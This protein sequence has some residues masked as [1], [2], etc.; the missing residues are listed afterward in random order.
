[1]KNIRRLLAGAALL[2][3]VTATAP[4]ASAQW[5][6]VGKWAVADGMLWTTPGLQ[7]YSGREAAALLFGGLYTNYAISTNGTDPN[8]I[9]FSAFLDGYGDTQFLTAPKGQDFKD[10]TGADYQSGTPA[11]SAYVF[12]HACDVLGRGYYCDNGGGELAINYAFVNTTV[13]EPGTYALMAFG[14]V[15]MV[16]V[17]RKRRNA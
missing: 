12:D 15:G 9:N 8:Q 14:L 13:P 16:G 7:S 5:A 6:Y 4:T 3:G 10:Q 2:I 1:M 11:Y 17:A